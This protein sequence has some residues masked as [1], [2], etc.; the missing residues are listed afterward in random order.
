MDYHWD[1]QECNVRGLV[2]VYTKSYCE[3][4]T[5]SIPDP[6]NNCRETWTMS[7][8]GNCSNAVTNSSLD[9]FD[10]SVSGTQDSDISAALDCEID[11]YTYD[12][13][14]KC[15]SSPGVEPDACIP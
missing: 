13:D 11:Q 6:T 2:P 7:G 12:S 9:T 1:G 14:C 4:F 8:A 10:H 15:G 3:T 5:P